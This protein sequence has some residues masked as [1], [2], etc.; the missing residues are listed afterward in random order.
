MTARLLQLVPEAVDSG[1]DGTALRETGA[2][3]GE[4]G[5]IWQQVPVFFSELAARNGW[6]DPY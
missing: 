6:L 4:D 5:E 1:A 3:T 2:N